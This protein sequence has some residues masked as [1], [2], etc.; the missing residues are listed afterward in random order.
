MQI[1]PFFTLVQLFVLGN[2]AFYATIDG[3]V[4]P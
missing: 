3:D 4:Q 1:I 2:C